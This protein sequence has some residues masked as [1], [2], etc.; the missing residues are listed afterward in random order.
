MILHLA[1]V[2]RLAIGRK[3]NGLRA[4][5]GRARQATTAGFGFGRNG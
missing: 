4:Q 3:K 5:P 2:G 1:R